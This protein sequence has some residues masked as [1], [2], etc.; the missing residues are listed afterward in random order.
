MPWLIVL[1]KSV[2]IS[3]SASVTSERKL[4]NP[5]RI[6]GQAVKTWKSQ[7]LI[8]ALVVSVL[9]RFVEQLT[10]LPLRFISV[11]ARRTH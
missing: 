4:R 6:V 8:I 11:V 7:F 2:D 3:T 10:H 9:C 5:L 1:R